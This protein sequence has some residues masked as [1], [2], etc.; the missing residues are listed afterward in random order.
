MTETLK[1]CIERL[2]LSISSEFVP[3]SKSRKAETNLRSLNWIITL[4]RNGRDILTTDYSAGIAHCPAYEASKTK[5]PMKPDLQRAIDVETET[6][7]RAKT[8]FG[9]RPYPSCDSIDPNPVDVIYSLAMESDV[10][11]YAGFEDWA[12]SFGYDTDS[13]NAEKIYNACL[14]TAL[15]LRAAIGETAM[16]ALRAAASEY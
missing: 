9:G 6:G 15:K 14:V 3:F 1:Q 11:D 12:E 10:I 13:R 8:D 7:K 2:G 4:V 16:N 5:W